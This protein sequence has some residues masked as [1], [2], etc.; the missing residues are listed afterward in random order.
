MTKLSVGP[1]AADEAPGCG[2][3][4]TGG[5]TKAASNVTVNRFLFM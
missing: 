5:A 2:S 1:A 3:A 4:Q